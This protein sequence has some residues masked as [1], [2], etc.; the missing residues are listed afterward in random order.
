MDENATKQQPQTATAFHDSVNDTFKQKQQ[1]RRVEMVNGYI[2]YTRRRKRTPH[3]E[4]EKA[5]KRLKTCEG[6]TD[7]D[8][9]A[10]VKVENSVLLVSDE[11]VRNDDAVSG[12]LIKRHRR[13]SLKL[14]FDSEDADAD[15]AAVSA[16]ARVANAKSIK[17]PVTVKELF[18]TG[19]LDGVPVVY[20][21]CKKVRSSFISLIKHCIFSFY[22]LFFMSC[23]LL[24]APIICY[25][26]F[27][28]LF[29][30]TLFQVK[31]A[32]RLISV[33]QE[34]SKT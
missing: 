12:T 11:V 9:N 8:D 19:L 18:D 23:I 7:N 13:P 32:T 28:P 14:K 15:N 27:F 21:G 30:P 24:R 1:Q 10:Q 17:K 29:S 6:G 5:A 26:I 22:Y 25:A 31:W 4:N 2:V 34:E 3:S 33:R 20:L 16:T